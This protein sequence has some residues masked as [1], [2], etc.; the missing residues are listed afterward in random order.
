MKKALLVSIVMGLFSSLYANS[1]PSSTSLL[2]EQAFTQAYVKE[3]QKHLKDAKLKVTGDLSIEI[4]YDKGMTTSTDLTNS[5]LRYSQEKYLLEDVFADHIN[6]SKSVNLLTDESKLQIS[7]LRPVIKPIT[8]I[9]GLTAKINESGDKNI[10]FPFYYEP[11]NDELVLML[12]IDTPASIQFVGKEKLD[13]L[14]LPAEQLKQIAKTN[15]DSHLKKIDAKFQKI[16]PENESSNLHMFVADDNYEA[17]AV[18]SDYFRQQVKATFNGPVGIV[19]PN[20]SSVLVVP[21]DD[22]AGLYQ[23]AVFAYS[24]FPNLSYNVSPFAYTYHDGELK[25]IQF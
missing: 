3:A 11:I 20:R 17:S 19:F 21:L 7:Q 9:E 13:E 6:S 18:F 24:E 2:S 15:L 5:Y 1:S 14:N 22:E 8:Y 16:E 12:A 10:P 4:T 23:I 25:R